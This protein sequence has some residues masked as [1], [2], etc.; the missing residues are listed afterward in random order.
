MATL[1]HVPVRFV[2]LS[3]V[4][5][6]QKDIVYLAEV[7]SSTFWLLANA[8]S[9]MRNVIRYA[10][11]M[12]MDEILLERASDVPGVVHRFP[13]HH[14]TGCARRN[15]RWRDYWVLGTA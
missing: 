1:R 14:G 3:P 4:A 10:A 15:R 9:L 6:L 12:W 5:M 11:S 13:Q 8:E 7:L 2:T